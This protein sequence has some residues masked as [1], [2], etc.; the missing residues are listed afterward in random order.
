LKKL[1]ILLLLIPIV[2]FGEDPFFLK[3]NGESELVKFIGTGNDKE[4]K[5]IPETKT[6]EVGNDYLIFD[7]KKFILKKENLYSN[8]HFNKN[9]KY[10]NFSKYKYD[11]SVFEVTDINGYVNRTTGEIKTRSSFFKSK[12]EKNE[13]HI[14]NHAYFIGKCEEVH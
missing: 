13:W 11:K 1:L 8:M 2:S 7:N 6:I 4:I 3:C 10:I 5:K 12:D 9:E 14:E